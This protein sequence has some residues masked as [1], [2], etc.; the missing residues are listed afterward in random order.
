[1]CKQRETQVRR[2]GNLIATLFTCTDKALARTVWTQ[3]LCYCRRTA[4][5]FCSALR[6][7]AIAQTKLT[8][9]PVPPQRQ[10]AVCTL[11]C[12]QEC[13]DAC[14]CPIIPPVA[15]TFAVPFA[16]HLTQSGESTYTYT[17]LLSI[18]S[19]SLSSSLLTSSFQQLEPI[20]NL[21]P[22]SHTVCTN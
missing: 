16:R 12:H 21:T 22:C 9:R 17:E 10:H 13:D 18:H 4:T 8:H 7:R 19:R 14:H 3:L 15:T 2:M 5:P 1:M 20:T 11:D 6:I